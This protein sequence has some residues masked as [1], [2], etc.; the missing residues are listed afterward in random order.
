LLEQDRLSKLLFNIKS[1]STMK[2]I[3]FKLQYWNSS[4]LE[5]LSKTC[6]TLAAVLMVFCSCSLA[7][8][9]SGVV[10]DTDG[11]TLIGV[12]ILVKGTATG[13]VSDF[14][15]QFSLDAASGETL[16]FSYTGYVNKEVVVGNQTQINVTMANDVAILDE[17]VVVGYGTQR[18]V[19]LT[20]AVGSIGAEEI[21]KTP[22]LSADQALRGRLAGV[23]L[24]N[25]S[26]ELFKR[27]ILL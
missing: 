3:N 12:N 13:T 25:R 18:K 26:G 19:D 21:A 11:E 9:V 16:V 20:G 24:T 14:D 4:L 5:V 10:T 17:V 23:Q 1:K 15:G 8:Q 22:I 6:R 2:L 27:Q 7:A